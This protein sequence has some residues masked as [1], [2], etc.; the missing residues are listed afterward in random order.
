MKLSIQ[1][2]GITRD[3]VGQ[4]H[5][6]YFAGDAPTV[7]H[8]LDSLRVQY[9]ALAG[10]RSLVVAVNNEYAEAGQ[11]LD[12]RDEIALIPPVAGG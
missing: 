8:L 1:L 6:E 11:R 4:A 2:F 10:L 12:A 7:Q 3:I 5:M 9:P